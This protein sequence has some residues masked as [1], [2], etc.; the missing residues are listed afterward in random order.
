ML[1]DRLALWLL[2]ASAS[3]IQ[4]FWAASSGRDDFDRDLLEL[5]FVNWT[6]LDPASAFAAVEGTRFARYPWMGWACHEPEKALHEVLALWK[7]N[8]DKENRYA[9]Y[10]VL[11]SLGKYQ[12]TWLRKNIDQ[13]PEG[14]MREDA[15]ASFS[16]S[17]GSE[18]AR[19][20]VE[21]LQSQGYPLGIANL[22]AL[23]KESPVEAYQLALECEESPMGEN[24][25]RGYRE[26]VIE[27]LSSDNPA[28]LAALAR[29]VTPPDLKL[30]VQRKQFEAL[31]KIDPEAAEE[32]MKKM[33]ES[34]AK[35]DLLAIIAKHS[36]EAQAEKSIELVA[37]LFSKEED[38]LHRSSRIRVEGGG[39]G[40]G[41]TNFLLEEV[42]HEII[43]KDPRALMT[44]VL[45]E[46][47]DQPA[48]QVPGGLQ[49]FGNAWAAANLPEFAEWV[50]EQD[51]PALYQ[52][53]AEV[54]SSRLREKFQF[55][56]SLEW[57]QSIQV[58]ESGGKADQLAN[59]Y[60]EWRKQDAEA[61]QT[62]KA[63]AHLDEATRTRF[64][65]S[66]QF[67]FLKR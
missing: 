33:P 67:Q 14:W 27:S 1:Y 34:W 25:F 57:I 47:G 23:A 37:A 12:S 30:R 39:S 55:R 26:Q 3:E 29:L 22:T 35:E 52:Y 32:Q 11:G 40:S 48:S 7:E 61:A 45:A 63:A 62:W 41:G 18:N 66:E 31:L 5:I 38:P 64:D 42:V 15:L 8:G 9:V 20:T 46:L 44:R 13:V 36:L 16:R 43:A 2:D 6:R 56:E 10:S 51:Q 59:I 4:E 21:F 58:D 49:S 50:S 17:A 53:G 65:R 28:A 24:L 60:L 19:E 54:V